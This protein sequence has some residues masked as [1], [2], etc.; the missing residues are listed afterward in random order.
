MADDSNQDN[1]DKYSQNNNQNQ[2]QVVH[3]DQETHQ[4]ARTAR[5]DTSVIILDD[6]DNMEAYLSKND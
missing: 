4:T 3:I 5:N 1:L 2:H 6:F